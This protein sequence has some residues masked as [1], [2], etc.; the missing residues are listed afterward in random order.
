MWRIRKSTVKVVLFI[1]ILL[2]I[3]IFP[4]QGKAVMI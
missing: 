3:N 1:F 4:Y 2:F